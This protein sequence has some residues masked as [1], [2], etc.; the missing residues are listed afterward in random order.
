MRVYDS[1]LFIIKTVAKLL[2]GKAAISSHLHS[3]DGK[4]SPVCATGTSLP[5]IT[6]N[7]DVKPQDLMALTVDDTAASVCLHIQSM[8]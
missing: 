8:C 3:L 6:Q 4:I 5:Q 1:R 2:N 7:V